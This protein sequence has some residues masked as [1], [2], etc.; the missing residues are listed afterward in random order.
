[1]LSAPNFSSQLFSTSQVFSDG[2]SFLV[3]DTQPYKRLCLSVGPSIGQLIRQSVGSLVRNDRVEKWENH[4]SA[5]GGRVSGLV[6]T[7]FLFFIR[8]GINDQPFQYRPFRLETFFYI[9]RTWA[10]STIRQMGQCPSPE[11]PRL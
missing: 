3:A 4:P 2:Q 11:S 7:T 5:T 8:V 10:E 6:N 1:M 9:W